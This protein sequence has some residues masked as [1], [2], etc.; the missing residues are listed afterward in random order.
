MPRA[1]LLWKLPNLGNSSSWCL[2]WGGQLSGLRDCLNLRGLKYFPGAET[3]N[4][5]IAVGLK[6]HG[7]CAEICILLALRHP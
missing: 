2:S 7:L 4:G 3:G 1:P 5:F 6:L